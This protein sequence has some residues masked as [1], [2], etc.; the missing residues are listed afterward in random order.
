[1][2]KQTI[3]FLAIMLIGAMTMSGCTQAEEKTSQIPSS[4]SVEQQ[5]S[6]EISQPDGSNTEQELTDEEILEQVKP[7]L[8]DMVYQ[9]PSVYP[10]NNDFLKANLGLEENDVSSC[11]L[12][13]G[14]PNQNTG[15][16]LM[17]TRTPEA[18][19]THILEK[20]ES[21]AKSM[22]ETAEMGYTEGYDGYEIIEKDDRIFLVMHEDAKQFDEL[23][24]LL[25]NL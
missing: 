15:F 19:T 11:V 2:K 24:A 5:E 22:V 17:L 14:A 8:E 4:S 7:Y 10:S 1:M 3:C 21:K 16:F 6:Q 12:Y 9:D 20:L 25:E 18:D 23:V 13:M